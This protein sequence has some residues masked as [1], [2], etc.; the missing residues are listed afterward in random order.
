MVE[1][2]GLSQ[3]GGWQQVQEAIQVA[4]AMS[5]SL[6]FALG[7]QYLEV[8]FGQADFLQPVVTVES[9]PEPAHF[10]RVDQ[11]G[12]PLAGS[13]HQPFTALQT[14]L[15]ACHDPGRYTLLFVVVGDGA[16]NRIY[17]GVRGHGADSKA[18]AFIDYLGHFLETPH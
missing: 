12:D 16:E 1:D 9:S 5:L 3:A 15:S 17:L 11:V 4:D 10:L 8:P 7:R 13:L 2:Q 18:Y 6:L 14:A